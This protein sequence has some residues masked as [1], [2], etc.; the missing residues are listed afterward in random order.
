MGCG[1]SSTKVESNLTNNSPLKEI[2]TS[3]N[4]NQSILN[5][6]QNGLQQKEIVIINKNYQ[7]CYNEEEINKI[8]KILREK[9]NENDEII[10]HKD[11]IEIEKDLT[12][13]K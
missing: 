8:N 11:I 12:N 1:H 4:E 3:G 13:V 10:F 6:N 9:N 2:T 5:Q 7:Y